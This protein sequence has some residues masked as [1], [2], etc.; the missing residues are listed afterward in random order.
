MTTIKIYDL[1]STKLFCTGLLAIDFESILD[2]FIILNITVG[3][4]GGLGF[5][6]LMSGR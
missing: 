6:L 1:Y 4:A 3:I 5:I 2:V